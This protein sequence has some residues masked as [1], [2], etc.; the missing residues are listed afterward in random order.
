MRSILF[1]D[2]PNNTSQE[3][4]AYRHFIKDLMHNGFY[5]IQESGAVL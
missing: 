1:F 3:K 4:R 5:R 2:L